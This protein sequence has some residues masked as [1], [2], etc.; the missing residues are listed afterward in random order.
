MS[1]ELDGVLKNVSFVY[2]TETIANS[3]MRNLTITQLNCAVLVYLDTKNVPLS[4]I[5]IQ[6]K[7]IF[8]SSDLPTVLVIK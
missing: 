5:D 4:F 8:E 2:L 6:K 1:I 3:P 7:V